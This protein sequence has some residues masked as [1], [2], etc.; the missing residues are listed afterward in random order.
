MCKGLRRQQFLIQQH[1]QTATARLPARN[2]QSRCFTSYD[3]SRP[4]VSPTT[5]CQV[6]PYR[7]SSVS[8]MTRAALYAQ[9][10]HIM[11]TIIYT[12]IR[13]CFKLL[14]KNSQ[15]I[16]HWTIHQ[17]HITQSIL[18]T[19]RL[20]IPYLIVGTVFFTCSNDQINRLTA[21]LL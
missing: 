11:I 19:N 1:F 20:L 9:Y 3:T 2:I 5:Q 4:N 6:D 16:I 13:N 8:L 15:M 12:L 17:V 14:Y 10:G 18:I 7:L 21:H